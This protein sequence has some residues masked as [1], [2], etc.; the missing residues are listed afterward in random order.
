MLLWINIFRFVLFSWF[1]HFCITIYYTNLYTVRWVVL[2][3]FAMINNIKVTIFL[4]TGILL[5]S[6]CLILE[7]PF[8]TYV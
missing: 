3:H 2:Q 7:F 6:E 1:K 5:L 4:K 8:Y